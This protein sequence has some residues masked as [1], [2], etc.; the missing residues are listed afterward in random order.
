[1]AAWSQTRK[2]SY[3][4][5][6]TA[7]AFL[8]KQP[9]PL[10]LA[11][12]RFF[13]TYIVSE[14]CNGTKRCRP[15]LLKNFVPPSSLLKTCD[16][17]RQLRMLLSDENVDCRTLGTCLSHKGTMRGLF[18]SSLIF[19]VKLAG[20]RWID[21]FLA[22]VTFFWYFFCYLWHFICQG[23]RPGARRMELWQLDRGVQLRRRG[24]ERLQGLQA[25]YQVERI[26]FAF[27][28]IR[29]GENFLLIQYFHRLECQTESAKPFKVSIGWGLWKTE[30]FFRV[31]SATIFGKAKYEPTGMPCVAQSVGKSFWLWTARKQANN[32]SKSYQWWQCSQLPVL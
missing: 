7:V 14:C 17:Q 26:C 12:P 16:Q 22:F 20:S 15:V 23:I 19:L 8:L 6:L 9:A 31:C 32:R 21:F 13:V 2:I 5:I 27:L 1:M 29:S 30:I 3:F 24:Q 11:V 18:L 10:R 28:R 4:C 25:W